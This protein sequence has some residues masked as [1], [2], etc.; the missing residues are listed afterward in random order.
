MSKNECF[1]IIIPKLFLY[2]VCH[3][4]GIINKM[5]KNLIFLLSIICINAVYGHE[6]TVASFNSSYQFVAN[7]SQ[8]P[9]EVLFKSEIPAGQAYVLKD[10]IYY[11]FYDKSTYTSKSGHCHSCQQEARQ[12][13]AL[14]EGVTMHGIK[15]KFMG[16]NPNVSVIG[17]EA[18]ESKHNYFLGNDAS[19][20]ASNCRSYREVYYQQMYPGIDV[21]LYSRQPNLKYDIIVAPGADPNQVKIEYQ[22]ADDIYLKNGQLTIATSVGEV[23]E[24]LPLAYQLI[25]GDSVVV[26]CNFDLQNNQISFKF[27]DNYNAEYP[28]IIDPELV[29]STYSGSASDNWG[30]TATFDDSGNLYSGGIVTSPGYN[31]TTGAY[32]QNFGGGTWDLLILKFDSIGQNLLYATHLGGAASESPESLIVNNAGELVILGVTS[33]ANFPTVNP[34]QASFAGGQ[35]SEI[36]VGVTYVNGSDIFLAKLS[37]DGSQLLGATYLGGQNN[38]AVMFYENQ[39]VKNYGDQ[40]RGDVIVDDNDNVYIASVTESPDIPVVNGWQSSFASLGSSDGYVAKLSPDLSNLIWSSFLGGSDNDVALSVKLWQ[41]KVIYGGGTMSDD[42]PTSAGTYQDSKPGGIDGFITIID[43]TVPV[44]HK[45][46][47]IGSS[48]YDQV[49]FIDLDNDGYIHALGQTDGDFPTKAVEDKELY[50]NENSGQ[51][52]IKLNPDLEDDANCFSTVFGSGIGSPNISP[53]AFLVNECGNML[54]SGHGGLEHGE[55][56]TYLTTSTT[57]G[58]PVTENAFKPTTDSMDFYIAAIEKDGQ[59]LLY[60]SFFGGNNQ[61]GDHV[62]G[63]TSRFDKRGIIYQ[64]VC[65]CYPNFTTT[66]NAYASQV[67]S[68]NCNNAAFKF[69]LASII[70][71]ISTDSPA[72]DDPGL[73]SGCWPLEVRFINESIGGNRF[74][75]DFGNGIT[76]EENDF[77][78]VTFENPGTY[79]IQLVALDETTCITS[80]T[81]TT[82]IEVYEHNFSIMPEDTIC[83]GDNIELRATG[84]STYQWAPAESLSNA[85]IAQPTATPGATTTYEV[86]VTNALGC[87]FNDNVTIN[88]VPKFVSDFTLEKL[89]NCTDHPQFVLTNTSTNAEMY[90]W[91]L[92]DGFTS[93]ETDLIYQFQDSGRYEIT[94]EAQNS[95]CSQSKSITV[96]SI[97]PKIPNVFTPNQDTKNEFFQI[98]T[99]APFQLDIFNRWGKKLKSW[100]DYQNNWNGEDLTNGIYYYQLTF[101]DKT[102]CNGWLHIL[103]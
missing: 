73:N 19:Q 9:A 76:S 11:N 4:M 97:V 63:G 77:V 18:G 87:E 15:M 79:T 36:L 50:E 51:F 43:Q 83:F 39:L 85:S 8:W 34:Y 78:D 101:S 6:P 89:F 25:A 12:T 35:N 55:V 32:Q 2:I 33:S 80:D 92:S 65:A 84:G 38:D 7:K 48:G 40:F 24:Q 86:V 93:S 74:K 56:S 44:L 72:M 21:K 46:T 64:S 95:I 71:R 60:G 22:G 37:N 103:R 90:E 28:L 52:I 27:D 75:W 59:S 45:S 17:K 16:S 26:R 29:F 69:D 3:S 58:M 31:T 54:L 68:N 14:P 70:A 99:D 5:I 53:T 30:N 100:D 13:S 66:P 1:S 62:D 57:Y 94:L 42:F 96:S 49:Y 88:V 82:T 61:R 102:T 81:A 91:Q 47:Y 23:Y 67:G 41:N 10:G 20:W 98:T